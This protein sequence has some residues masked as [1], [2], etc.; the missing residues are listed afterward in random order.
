[1]LRVL[2]E[3]SDYCDLPADL[4]TFDAGSIVFW[5]EGEEVGR[6][7]QARIRQIELVDTRSMTHRIKTARRRHP[8]AFRPWTQEDEDL[9]V[10]MFKAGTTKDALM[11]ALGRQEGGIITRLRGLN[12]LTESETLD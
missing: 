11:E 4:M 1:V 6:Q 8:N 7:R 5:R 9:L 10:K 12:L 2:L 3:E